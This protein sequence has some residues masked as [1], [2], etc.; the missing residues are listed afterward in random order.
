MSSAALE[1][2]GIQ[3]SFGGV[4]ALKDVSLQLLAG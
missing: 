3:K 1:A 4:R 2:N